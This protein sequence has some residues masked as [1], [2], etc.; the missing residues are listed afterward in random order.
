MKPRLPLQSHKPPSEVHQT[1]V[2]NPN[3]TE[4]V[5]ANVHQSNYH[6]NH[7]LN[8]NATEF[9]PCHFVQTTSTIV[10]DPAAEE[11]VPFLNLIYSRHY[12]ASSIQCLDSHLLQMPPSF[13][14]N[15]SF[16]PPVPLNPEADE[17]APN[18]SFLPP[19]LLNPDADGFVPNP[20]FLPSAPLNPEAAEFVPCAASHV[21]LSR[22]L[23]EPQQAA[24]AWDELSISHT[25][26]EGALENDHLC[27]SFDKNTK[28][29]STS[30]SSHSHGCDKWI[31]DETSDQWG[32]AQYLDEWTVEGKGNVAVEESNMDHR[33]RAHQEQGEKDETAATLYRE[34]AT[35]NHK[36]TDY[37]PDD[38]GKIKPKPKKKKKKAIEKQSAISHTGEARLNSNEHDK[39]PCPSHESHFSKEETQEEAWGVIS[40][41]FEVED[42]KWDQCL[43]VPLKESTTHTTSTN[44]AN[45]KTNEHIDS[46]TGTGGG[47]ADQQF[48]NNIDGDAAK[49]NGMDQDWN[50]ATLN[51]STHVIN[52]DREQDNDWHV[53]ENPL[54]S[55]DPKWDG[56][57][58][59]KQDND[60]HV[61][62]DLLVN[63]D[64]KWEGYGLE[65]Q[66]DN[67]FSENCAKDDS[68][69]SKMEQGVQQSKDNETV[70]ISSDRK[71]K[72]RRRRRNKKNVRGKLRD[73]EV[74]RNSFAQHGRAISTTEAQSLSEER[75]R[76][77]DSQQAVTESK[78]SN[79][80]EGKAKGSNSWRSV[81]EVGYNFGIWPNTTHQHSSFE[82][83]GGR[84][85]VGDGGDNAESDP[86]EII[87]QQDAW[88]G[89]SRDKEGDLN[90]SVTENG[91]ASDPV[92]QTVKESGHDVNSCRA[93]QDEGLISTADSDLLTVKR[94]K[95]LN[96][97]DMTGFDPWSGAAA[98][99]GQW[100]PFQG[101]DERFLDDSESN[102][103]ESLRRIAN[104]ETGNVWAQALAEAKG[105]DPSSKDHIPQVEKRSDVCRQR[106][107]YD[108]SCV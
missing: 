16:H 67:G 41:T 22:E 7:S 107:V 87:E 68:S 106:V 15:A 65:E 46:W 84:I 55:K 76:R 39:L 71:P 44:D 25:E 57:E 102:A 35:L 9:V 91:I 72:S 53:A 73:N 52:K 38:N 58:L 42:S 5:P 21:P 29:Q 30:P 48:T 60:W 63:K 50:E 99:E 105:G 45:W 12:Q 81:S 37:L 18:P 59:D 86:W 62:E 26:N 27:W 80:G 3:A 89:E 96:A 17:F 100:E 74:R 40:T 28:E 95:K 83:D 43:D 19:V 34:T 82:N 77:R 69:K 13:K 56:Y 1:I 90:G 66:K 51:K 75:K 36:G 11:F 14:P 85:G 4:F 49:W 108:L 23:P 92:E 93:V 2:L 8:P 97:L 54:I 33:W 24:N 98:P 70:R 47:A 20:S 79:K 94:K 103:D 101:D 10:L 32:S 78:N 61:T 6:H 104:E 31:E 88:D 64:S